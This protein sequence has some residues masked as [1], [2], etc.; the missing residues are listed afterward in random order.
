MNLSPMARRKVRAARNQPLVDMNL[1]SLI[2]IFT[3]LIF[4]LLSN[5]T[6]VE[7]LPNSKAVKLPESISDKTP[8]DSVVVVVNG[9]EILVQGHKVASVADV[10]ASDDD[11]IEPLKAE[12]D[13]QASH[14]L[15]RK[16]NTPENQPITIMGDKAIPYRL[17]RKVMVTCAR[18]NFS[19]VSFA[20]QRKSE[21]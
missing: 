19:E 7:I 10:L 18:A 9:D 20:V 6:D 14:A 1:V 5:S 4:F 3:I 21:S 17:L 16:D 2:D 8:K 15:V 11:L 13:L 12:L